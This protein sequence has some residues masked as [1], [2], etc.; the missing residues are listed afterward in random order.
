MPTEN[1]TTSPPLVHIALLS[2]GD[3]IRR[4]RWGSEPTLYRAERDGLLVARR[5]GRRLGY[6]W[7][8]IWAFEG[9]QPPEGREAEY[10]ADLL[11]PEVVAALCPYAPDTVVAMARRG[12]LPFRQVGQSCRFVPAEVARWIEGWA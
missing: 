8:D 2:R 7:K 1:P 9:G 11:T 10:R 6:A 3:L 4:W 12:D 5:H